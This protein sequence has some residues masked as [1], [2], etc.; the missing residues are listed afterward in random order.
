[1]QQS[2]FIYNH[3]TC[4]LLMALRSPMQWFTN[5]SA[6]PMILK[7]LKSTFTSTKFPLCLITPLHSSSHILAISPSPLYVWECS[8]SYPLREECIFHKNE[9]APSM[10]QPLLFPQKLRYLQSYR[11]SNKERTLHL[12]VLMYL[13]KYFVLSLWASQFINSPMI[14]YFQFN[15]SHGIRTI[16]VSYLHIRSITLHFCNRQDKHCQR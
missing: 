8:K 16:K 10:Q 13:D 3:A 7:Q 1:M 11:I 14:I 12:R 2:Q 6:Y 5:F 9:S 4:I 15:T